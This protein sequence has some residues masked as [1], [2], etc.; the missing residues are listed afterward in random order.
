MFRAPG[1]PKEEKE[2]Q[3][4]TKEIGTLRQGTKKRR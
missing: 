1:R 2:K 3:G 4:E